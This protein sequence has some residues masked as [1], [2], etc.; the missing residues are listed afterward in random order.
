MRIW[1]INHYAIPPTT[2]GGTRHYNFAR[3]LQKRGHE[4]VIIAANYNHSSH[5]YMGSSQKE[6]ELDTRYEV[7]FVWLPVPA[8]KGNT[9]ARFWNMLVFMKAILKNKT[10]PDLP[11]PD[12]ILGSSPHLFAA[13][14]AE[15]LARRMKK[16]FILE[17]RDLW[18]ESLVDLGRFTH[19][20]PL[21][22]GMKSIE[23]YLYKRAQ[24]VISLLPC[25]D[26]YLIQEG[27]KAE[28]IL[29]LPNSVDLSA[30]PAEALVPANNV[31]FTIM[32]AGAHGVAND[33]DTVLTAAKILQNQGLSDQIRICLV[34]EGP[35][36]ARLK[37]RATE[38]GITMV[39]F[40]DAVPK[41]QVYDILKQ[42]DAFLMLLKNSPVFRW[43]ISP[44]KLFDYLA[45]ERPV[46]FAVSTPF[47]P[48]EKA[49]AGI[50]V[51]PG[52]PEALATA[53]YDL[54]LTPK[55]KLQ[56]MGKR[57]KAFVI[58][59]HDLYRLS[60]SLE[61]LMQEVQVKEKLV[62]VCALE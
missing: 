51:N 37:K 12:L 39:E 38:E 13:L 16:P 42:A 23:R 19:K 50:S 41:S 33:L 3:Q 45:M 57:G 44:N 43:G 61:K 5:R 53:I 31:K 30:I 21:I 40:I 52:E 47:N 46:I 48:I 4:V 2:A 6:A 22:K 8:Y 62:E 27:V 28:N 60:L 56:A 55:E 35:E 11:E 25:A 1:M 54:Y 14:G 18:P 26:Q 10:L 59:N 24:R 9:L 58:E 29:W 34:G 20:H 49:Q 36:K 15:L 17:I 32:N 7:P